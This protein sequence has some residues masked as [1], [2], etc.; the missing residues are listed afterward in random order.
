MYDGNC[1]YCHDADPGRFKTPPDAVPAL[2]RSGRVPA[3]RFSLTD[4]D[5]QALVEYLKAPR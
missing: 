5:M 4:A 1:I 3:H 2:L